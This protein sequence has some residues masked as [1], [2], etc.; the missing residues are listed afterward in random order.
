MTSVRDRRPRVL[1]V[2]QSA[3]MSGAEHSLLDLMSGIRDRV[4]VSAACP[5][6][7]LSEA[8]VDAGFEPIRLRGTTVSFRLHLKHTSR[9]LRDIAG[10][11]VRVARIARR[12]D[13]D[14]VHA[15][16]A[17]AGLIATLAARIGGR[18]AVVHIRDWLPPGRVSAATARI[19]EAGADALIANSAYTAAQLPSAPARALR[20][21][22]HNPIDTTSFDP[23]RFETGAARAAIGLADDDLVLSIVGQVTPWKGQDDAIRVAAALRHEHP[24]LRLVIAGSPKFDD[25][26]TRFDNLG[27]DQ[28][29]RDMTHEE[30]LDEVVRFLGERS[31]VPAVLAATDVLLVPSWQEAFGRVALEG[32]AMGVPVVATNRGGPTELVRDGTDGVLLAPRRVPDWTR[33]VGSLLTNPETRAAMGR[34]GRERA[35]TEFRTEVHV[36]RIAA[37]YDEVLFAGAT[38]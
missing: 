27:F 31:D 10:D 8:M 25:P 16:T 24:R 13:V 22:V 2:N 3:T 32:M 18:P 37:I 14:L 29:I 5:S 6:G 11:A 9:G 17:R 36:E 38:R 34:N 23:A 1:Y 30:G 21:V 35:V 7:R 28:R 12:L 33:A 20:R 15:N 4:G 19:L 26:G